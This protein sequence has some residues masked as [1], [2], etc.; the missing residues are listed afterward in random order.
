MNKI[1]L[2]SAVLNQTPLDWENNFKNIIGSIKSAKA[3]GAVL[4]CLP[5][6]CVS[7]YGCEDM[8]L[9]S[10]VYE[11]SWQ[12]LEKILPHTQNILVNAGLPLFFEGEQYN[13][14][15]FF[16]NG[17]I[18]GILPKKYLA[19]EGVYYEGRWFKAWPIG[20]RSFLEIQDF[21]IPMGDLVFDFGFFKLGFE[22]CEEAWVKNRVLHH[23]VK[24]EVDIVFNPSASHFA[25][26]KFETRKKL[27]LEASAQYG[28]AYVYSNLLGNEA[29]RL[30]FDGGALI[31][32]EGKIVAQGRRFSFQDYELSFAEID[33]EKNRGMRGPVDPAEVENVIRVGI[34][35]G[36]KTDA[37]FDGNNEG[38]QWEHWENSKFIK[39]EE[40]FRVLCLALFDYLR[41]SK[42]Q[43]FVISLSGGVDSA[44]C[45]MLAKYALQEA[46]TELGIEQFLKKLPQFNKNTSSKDWVHCVYQ[47][48][49]NNSEHTEVAA[50]KL[51][52]VLGLSFYEWNI[53]EGVSFYVNTL[54]KA[55]DVKLN[56]KSDPLAL[57]N[58]QARARGPAVWLLANLK[59]ALLLSTS[60]RS[61][62]AVGYTTMDG[63]TCGSVSPIAG[64]NKTFLRSWLKWFETQGPEN[65][66]A[67]PELALINQLPPSAE[68]KPLSEHQSDEGDLMPYV[69]LDALETL[70]IRDK[71]SPQECLNQVQQKF[72]AYEKK[73]L[74]NWTR[75]FFDL[76]C[77]SQWKR[78]R[79]A[80][81]FHLDDES[82]DPK[83][84]CRFPILSSGFKN[85]LENLK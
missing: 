51:A 11:K 74:K 10:W 56:W 19:S 66:Q 6:L 79:Y 82:L 57:Q 33:L 44:V 15:V 14:T 41:K 53:D 12:M 80:L 36:L 27:V 20:K 34:D 16:G 39:E 2:A 43:G 60:N 71:H 5:E 3:S 4:L 63:D 84:W 21:E 9:S 55:L 73:Q 61:E 70:A 83:T 40:F 47:K 42:L 68:L 58:I 35:F 77:K 59:N 25:F 48:T 45:A 72:P 7:G 32:S 31:A 69:V 81:S 37:R 8:F 24:R 78:E 22:I 85:E 29:G 67:I 17:K 64:V 13:A 54:N 23:L 49:V 76:W 28:L 26:G 50:S 65:L 18:L 30:I 62:V 52:Q 1:Y 75:R 46:Q 38:H